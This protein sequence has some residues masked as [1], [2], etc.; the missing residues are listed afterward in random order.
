MTSAIC[1]SEGRWKSK[2][3]QRSMIVGITFWGSVVART[4]TVLGGGS[5]SVF[6]KAF[7]ASLVSMWASSRM[8][9]F[10]RPAAGAK[11]TR[12]RSS[13]MSSTERF[14][15]ASI[16][17]T[18]SEVPAAIV[19]HGSHSPHGVSVGPCTQLSDRARIFAIEVLPVPRE[20]MKR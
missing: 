10:Q 6:R 20:P 8:Y 1:S 13:R 12:S 2:R 17:I 4:K 7:Q 5:S 11:P 9:T 3:W 15:A 14:E 16:S 19:W 18:S